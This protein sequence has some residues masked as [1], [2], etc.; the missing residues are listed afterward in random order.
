MIHSFC[1]V[2]AVQLSFWSRSSTLEALPPAFPKQSQRCRDAA[3][4]ITLNIFGH[5]LDLHRQEPSLA[6]RIIHHKGWMRHYARGLHDV[7]QRLGTATEWQASA[8][9][10][11]LAGFGR[12]D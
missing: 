5:G 12:K 10:R 9:G 11:K 1:V 2:P 4:T 6:R 8:W 3:F 7:N